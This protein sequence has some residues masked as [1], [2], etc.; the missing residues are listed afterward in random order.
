VLKTSDLG[1]NNKMLTIFTDKIGKISTVA[2]GAKKN[3]SKF[4][5]LT[6]PLCY[7]EYMVFRGKNLY[8][9]NEG[10]I[11]DSFQEL[12]GDLTT[13]TYASYLCELIDISMQ[14]D[15]SN[16][17]LFKEFVTALYLIKTKAMDNQL[18]VRAF[19]LKLMRLTGYT[20][21]FENCSLCRKKIVNS[22]Y[23]SL[24][25]YGGVCDDCNKEHGMHISRATFNALKFLNNITLD[26][27]YRLNLSKEIK[28]ELYKINIS[29]IA[30]NY[31]RKPKS[32]Q[33]FDFIKESEGNE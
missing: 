29:L 5:S 32:L 4:L 26:K 19:E 8:T 31:S 1:E 13:L 3:K 11:I 28:E 23:I 25:Y 9:L 30:N 16:R 10:R 33:M 15:E 21:N 20:V 12:L 7:G 2:K 14:Q 22:N 18:L 6:Q 27:V 24:Q 17:E